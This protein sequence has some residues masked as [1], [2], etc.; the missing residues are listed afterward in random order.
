MGTIEELL[1]RVKAATGPDRRLDIAIHVLV[2]N[3]G[4]LGDY[5]SVDEYTNSAI[6][7]GWNTPRVTASIDAAIEL[8]ERVLSGWRWGVSFHSI[9]DG[10]YADGPFAGKLKHADGFR[11]HVTERS[12]LRPMPS[13]A[14]ARTAPL[15]ILAATLSALAQV[16]P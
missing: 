1:E 11:A 3:E 16:K 13:V 12:A 7:L 9:K 14:D 8:T 10:V 6:Q 4:R 5:A 2:T 15:A